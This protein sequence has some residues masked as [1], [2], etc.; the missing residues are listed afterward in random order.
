MACISYGNIKRKRLCN[1][2]GF[3]KI[4]VDFTACFMVDLTLNEEMQNQ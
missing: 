2:N 4:A 3:V 1:A